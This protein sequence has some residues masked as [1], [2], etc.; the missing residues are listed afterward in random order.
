MALGAIIKRPKIPFKVVAT[1]QEYGTYDKHK[2][3]ISAK[4]HFP[5]YMSPKLINGKIWTYVG[6][7]FGGGYQKLPENE[8]KYKEPYFGSIIRGLL[9]FWIGSTINEP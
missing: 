5:S 6:S 7:A 8:P 2:E 3:G 1:S 4:S 9:N